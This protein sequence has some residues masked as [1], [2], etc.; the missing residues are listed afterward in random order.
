M[1]THKLMYPDLI[2]RPFSCILP[3]KAI[4]QLPNHPTIF[5]SP[6]SSK[7]IHACTHETM[8]TSSDQLLVPLNL[9]HLA[10]M[11]K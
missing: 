2:L 6:Q 3:P 7:L 11:M 10:Q 1:V 5:P 9:Y 8:I 4:P